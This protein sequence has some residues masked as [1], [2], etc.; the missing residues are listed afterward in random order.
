MRPEYFTWSADERLRFRSKLPDADSTALIEALLKAYGRKRPAAMAKLESQGRI[1]LELQGEIN[2][3]M[4]PLVGIGEDSF[5]LSES[6]AADDSLLD[7]PTLLSYDQGDHAFQEES[8]K[9][10]DPKHVTRPYAGALHSTWARCQISGRLCYLTLSMAAWHL[11]ATMQEAAS[12][13]IERLVPHRHVPG[14]D[15]GTVEQGGLIRWDMRVEAD[16]QEGLLEELQRRTWDYEFRRSQEL[17]LEYRSSSQA[18]TFFIDNPYPGD[19]TADMNLLIVFSD[20]EA[21]ARV[22]FTSFLRDCRAIERPLQELELIED[23]EVQRIV[24]YV[25]EQHADLLRNFDPKVVTLRKRRKVMMHP[26]ALRD[27][28]DGAEQ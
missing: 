25:N 7:F 3:W 19:P 5:S 23:Q 11:Y 21:L 8:R 14:P 22:R 20:P 28:V 9:H 17:L 12:D 2:Q 24:V 10:D 27:I 26:E 18:A 15:D 6:F 1:P 16:G 4:Q 13:E